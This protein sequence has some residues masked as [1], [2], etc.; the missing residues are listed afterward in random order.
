M[1]DVSC[2]GIICQSLGV[3][4]KCP[5]GHI[6]QVGTRRCIFSI[7]CAELQLN[8]GLFGSGAAGQLGSD[9]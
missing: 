5:G 4:G 1:L 3:L 8:F 7:T 6:I 9:V 2:Q